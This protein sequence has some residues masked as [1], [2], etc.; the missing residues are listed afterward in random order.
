MQLQPLQDISGGWPAKYIRWSQYGGYTAPYAESVP[1]E[2][3]EIFATRLWNLALLDL[4]DMERK[5]DFAET[6]HAAEGRCC[7]ILAR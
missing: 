3:A 6:H 7:S 5:L 2:T 1:T 4:F